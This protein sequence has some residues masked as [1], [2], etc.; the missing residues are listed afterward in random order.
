MDQ[1][2]TAFSSDKQDLSDLLKQLHEGKLQ[3]PDFQ[4]GWVWNDAHIVS[5]LAS[6]GLSY[7]IGAIMTLETGN[8]DVRFQTR[9]VEG[10]RR[11][12]LPPPEHLILDGQQ[13][14]TSL[15]QALYS[16]EAVVMQGARNAE[17][18]RFYTLISRKP[19]TTVLTS[20]K[21]S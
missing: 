10:V 16:Q 15:Y 2:I 7:P 8:P 6:I 4:R 3:L 5:L 1:I 18:K 14:L 12:L 17:V 21:P 20:T 19:S 9:A 11:L 13:R